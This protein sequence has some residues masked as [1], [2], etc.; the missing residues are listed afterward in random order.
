MIVFKLVMKPD[1]PGYMYSFNPYNR[2]YTYF[3]H[4]PYQIDG[5][6]D[7]PETGD[8]TGYYTWNTIFWDSQFNVG[9]ILDIRYA[10]PIQLGTETFTFSTVAKATTTDYTLDNVSVYPNPYYGYHDMESSR[11]EKYVSFNNLPENATLDIYS[12]G[13]VFVKFKSQYLSEYSNG[14][15][16]KWDL[17]NQYGYPVASGMY[18]IRVSADGKDDKILKLALVQETQVLKYY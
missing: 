4:A 5:E 8:P 7:H 1:D 6:Y 12:L 15:H 11:S 13:G 10:N 16:V 2:M 3:I 9:D 14:Q 17:N 18:I